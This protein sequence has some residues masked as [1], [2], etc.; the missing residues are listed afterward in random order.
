MVGNEPEYRPRRAL[1]ND[2]DPA[3]P[4][5]EPSSEP[6][7]VGPAAHSASPDDDERKPLFRDEAPGTDT[8]APTPP[9][10]DDSTTI[11]A[12]TVRRSVAL[13]EG[14]ARP[15]GR[16]ART[17]LLIGA[18]AAVVILG[19][20]IGYSIFSLGGPK[21]AEPQPPASASPSGS[22]ST[23][24]SPSIPA[25]VLLTDA[26]MLT[27]ADAEAVDPKRTWKVAL[28][29]KGLDTDSPQA[30]CLG[31]EPAEGQP[32]PQQTVLRLL[33]SSGADAPGILH[34][35]DAYSTPEEAAQA[36]ALT[37]EALGGCEMAA[38]SIDFGQVVSGVGDQSLGLVL[39]VR[40]EATPEY[41]SVILSRTGRIVNVIDV[42]Q[43]GRVLAQQGVLEAMAA[44]TDEQ[45]ATSGGKC[46]EKPSLRDGPP[47]A[48]GDQPGFLTTGDLPPV[49]QPAGTWVG[50]TPGQPNPDFV[51][52]GCETT[53]FDKV[54]AMSV[55]ART[56]L[57][58]GSAGTLFGLDEIVLTMD[59]EKAAA[60][61][62]S[63]LAKDIT[64]CKSR[65]LTATV[66]EPAT[67]TG[68]GAGGA[69]ITGW[70]STVVQSTSAT[71]KITYRVGATV[72][73]AKV[74]Y[75]FL[76]T[77]AEKKLNLDEDQW[78]RVTVR[79]GQRASQVD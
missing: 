1:A 70:T 47:P 14:G 27:A 71:E 31:G 45:C 75:V 72:T 18:V 19:L 5:S 13:D 37:S 73:G 21:A 32:T 65:K 30:A 28:T 38:T 17:A 61:L 76:S 77:D 29:Q 56:Y 3:E 20:A 33:S 22:G 23:S 34:Q 44:V 74:V 9:R 25:S 35:A 4:D 64:S 42:A 10:L 16:R 49:G 58:E 62:A 8:A 63:D 55:S 12:P 67:V 6:T 52:S 24:A 59:D 53:R 79:A 11:L 2:G 54:D 41:R 51:G 68:V 60:A 43:K 39:A 48:G 78:N 57:L 66:T 7:E 50:D 26:S 46:T 69:K 15:G 40:D 36:Y